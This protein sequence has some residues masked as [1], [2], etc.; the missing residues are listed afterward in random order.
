MKKLALFTEGSLED[1]KEFLTEEERQG[2]ADGFLCGAC[3]YGAG[4][5]PTYRIPEDINPE[6]GE[7]AE[8]L[9]DFVTEEA[10]EQI[11]QAFSR[12]LL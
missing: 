7:T 4:S 11:K 9:K 2:Y 5:C 8:E 10:I 1:I 3:C 12:T 6:T